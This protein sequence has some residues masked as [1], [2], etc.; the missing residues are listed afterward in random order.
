MHKRAATLR[1]KYRVS[2]M[3]VGP[4]FAGL[5]PSNR[6]GQAPSGERCKQL[7]EAILR[8]GFDPNGAYYDGVCVQEAP[9]GTTIHNFNNK[10]CGGN[11]LLTPSVEG[12]QVMYGSL[13]HSHLNQNVQEYL[14]E[15]ASWRC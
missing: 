13:S 5:H 11:D 8:D 3:V 2:K 9:G 1:A 12:T 14:G 7:L 6:G 10:A 4:S 15:A